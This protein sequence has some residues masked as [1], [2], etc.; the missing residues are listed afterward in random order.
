MRR[1]EKQECKLKLAN[2]KRLREIQ[3]RKNFQD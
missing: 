1:I 2:N 3:N